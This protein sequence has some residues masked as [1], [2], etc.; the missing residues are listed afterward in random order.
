MQAREDLLMLAVVISLFLILT[1]AAFL[2]RRSLLWVLKR[3]TIPAIIH[4][5]P[6]SETDFSHASAYGVSNNQHVPEGW[7]TDAKVFSL[8]RRA[9]FA[10]VCKHG[11][12]S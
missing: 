7:F 1:T 4:P 5:R 10:T 8:E 3:L 9:I 12:F 2:S 11:M 6:S